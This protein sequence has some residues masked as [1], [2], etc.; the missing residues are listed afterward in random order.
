MKFD[1]GVFFLENLSRNFNF[2]L[3]L[4]I[5]T[6]LYLKTGAVRVLLYFV[7][8]FLERENF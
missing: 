4:T 2:D 1:I 6:A 5:L 8:F 7:Q 3:N